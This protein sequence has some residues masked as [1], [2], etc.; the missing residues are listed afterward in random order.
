M[1]IQ[2]MFY[3]DLRAREIKDDVIATITTT[4][5]RHCLETA[6]LYL[7]Q[8]NTSKATV[9]ENGLVKI[10]YNKDI[11]GSIMSMVAIRDV[12]VESIDSLGERSFF[13]YIRAQTEYTCILLNIIQSMFGA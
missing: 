10:D 3:S 1:Q 5:F 8:E 11:I 13:L 6:L 2:D 9:T 4:T 7:T 12:G